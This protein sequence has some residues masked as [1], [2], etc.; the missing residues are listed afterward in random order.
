M[1][2]KT[3]IAVFIAL[4][5]GLGGGIAVSYLWPRLSH[6]VDVL[7][8]KDEHG[9]HGHDEHEGEDSHLDHAGHDERAGHDHD[10]EHADDEEDNDHQQ[11]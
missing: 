10:G 1:D 9:G 3:T 4:A 11:T 6:D 5:V 7:A 2:R 8:S